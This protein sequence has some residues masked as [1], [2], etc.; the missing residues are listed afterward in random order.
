MK[1]FDDAIA[2]LDDLKEDSYKDSTL[3]MQ[4]LRDNLTVSLSSVCVCVRCILPKSIVPFFFC[5]LWTSDNQEQEDED[6]G[7]QS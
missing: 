5:Q 2:S 7:D 4:L 3:I 6:A 1:A